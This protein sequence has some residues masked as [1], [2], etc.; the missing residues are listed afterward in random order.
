MY[1]ILFIGYGS[2]S[3]KH[4]SII[5][6]NFNAKI[7]LI[8]RHFKGNKNINKI[9]LKNAL[10]SKFDYCFI[11]TSASER[12]NYLKLLKK[13]SNFFFLEKPISNDAIKVKKIFKD[14][15]LKKKLFIGYVFRKNLMIKNLQIFIKKNLKHINGVQV[16]SKSYMPNWRKEINYKSSVS[17]NKVNGG[18][19]YEL[20]HEIDLLYYLF[21]NINLYSANLSYSK[22]LDIKAED[23]A[24]IIFKFNKNKVVNLSLDFNS[25]ISERRIIINSDKFDI[26]ANINKNFFRVYAKNQKT[27]LFLF[28]NENKKMFERQI[29]DFFKKKGNLKDLNQSL[30]VL[31]IINEIKKY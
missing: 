3:K 12:I 1:N 16:I 10:K 17:S 27:K 9:S 7:F 26:D 11:C 15:K 14:S 20:S 8:S 31:R 29:K 22:D 13:N 21:N 5:K 4:I 18:V 28:K 24:D 30:K 25:Y 19:L 6:K 23:R 2:I